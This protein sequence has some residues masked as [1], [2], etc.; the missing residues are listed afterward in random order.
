VPLQLVFG[1]EH[2]VPHCPPL[3]IAPA[4]VSHFTPQPP[5][6]FGSLCVFVHT[7]RQ[8]MPPL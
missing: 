7:P 5:Q 1:E 4:A 6:L 8:S 2:V 3:Q